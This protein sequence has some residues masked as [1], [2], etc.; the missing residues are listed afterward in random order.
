MPRAKTTN[1]PEYVLTKVEHA[2][3]QLELS[4]KQV[5]SELDTYKDE[6]A[7]KKALIDAYETELAETK[8]LEEIRKSDWEREHNVER[9]KAF[10]QKRIELDEMTKQYAEEVLENYNLVP[11][12]NERL[13]Y[14]ESVVNDYKSAINNEV[15]KQTQTIKAEMEAKYSLR[16]ET[17]Y[18]N[19]QIE[20]TKLNSEVASLTSLL[21]SA[22]SERDR[23]FEELRAERTASVER[24]KGNTPIF[25]LSDSKK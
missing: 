11:V 12:N 20:V 22:R 17:E 10:R 9:Q 18:S 1:T 24:T 4:T 23:A 6:V 16:K 8:R 25:N 21:D 14:L 15:A 2:I 5:K 13:A 7:A 3:Q 19:M